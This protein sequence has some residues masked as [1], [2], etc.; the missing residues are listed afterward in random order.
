MES[1]G[2]AAGG[3]TCGGLAAAGAGVSVAGGFTPPLS[4]PPRNSGLMS[5]SI[6]TFPMLP[7][8]VVGRDMTTDIPAA[9]GMGC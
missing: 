3:S 1:G 7:L 2:R 8:S 9:G 4:A 5:D 6:D